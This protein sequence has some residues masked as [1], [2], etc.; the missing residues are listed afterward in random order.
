MYFPASNLRCLFCSVS[1]RTDKHMVT[2]NEAG[3]P[4]LWGTDMQDFF[5]FET[6]Q[7]SGLFQLS[8]SLAHRLIFSQEVSNTK[9]KLC[10]ALVG[11]Y[12]FKCRKTIQFILNKTLGLCYGLINYCHIHIYIYTHTYVC[13]KFYS[14]YQSYSHRS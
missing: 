7:A 13:A 12:K 1:C 9:K 4:C 8:L 11:K 2:S 10:K 3:T 14:G 6:P 5:L